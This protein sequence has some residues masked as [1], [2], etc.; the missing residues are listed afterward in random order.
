MAGLLE[1]LQQLADSSAPAGSS[2]S[3]ELSLQLKALLQ[4]L[5]PQKSAEQTNAQV[6]ERHHEQQAQ[7]V[8]VVAAAATAASFTTASC[9]HF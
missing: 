6:Q 5:Q 8:R 7:Q 1:Q 4:R 2:G 9:S 3:S